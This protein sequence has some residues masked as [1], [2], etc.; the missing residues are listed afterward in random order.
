VWH[1]HVKIDRILFPLMHVYYTLFQPVM[2][3]NIL[4]PS[5]YKYRD[6]IGREQVS[7]SHINLLKY[8]CT[9]SY[10]PVNQLPM[11]RFVARQQFILC[12]V[13]GHRC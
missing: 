11:V 3:N 1:V 12:Q 2:L 13:F 8:T 4:D 7:I 9:S 10:K 5:F 6:L